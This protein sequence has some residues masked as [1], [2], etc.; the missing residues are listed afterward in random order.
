MESCLQ[1]LHQK[2]GNFLCLLLEAQNVD[3]QTTLHL[4]CRRGSAE[5]VEAILEYKDANVDVLDKDG[6]SPLVF[7]LAAGDN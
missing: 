3:G 7:A 6:D 2:S 5:L 4:A 1:R